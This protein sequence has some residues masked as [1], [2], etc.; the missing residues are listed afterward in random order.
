M[1]KLKIGDSASTSKIFNYAEVKKYAE[2]S[3][4]SNPVHFDS[5]YAQKTHFKKPIVQGLLVSSL[6]GGLLGSK[7]PGRGTIH[8]GQKLNFR[9]P[10]FVNEK[11]NITIEIINIRKDKPVITFKTECYKE[12]GECAIDGEAV[13][14]YK[15]E[16]F[17]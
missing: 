2:F 10:V 12:N 13:V 7:L 8:L 15:G 16:L 17:I 9:K 3:R 1:K 4:D 5:S 14:M 6:F 11:V